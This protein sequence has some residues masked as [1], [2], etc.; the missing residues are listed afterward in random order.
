MKVREKVKIFGLK[1][2][3]V[4]IGGKWRKKFIKVCK[5]G[6]KVIEIL[7]LFNWKKS[8]NTNLFMFKNNWKNIYIFYTLH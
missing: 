7:I 2:N 1:V 4:K 8:K 6:E 5:W 3:K